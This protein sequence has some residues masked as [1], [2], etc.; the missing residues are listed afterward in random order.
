MDD[1]DRLLVAVLC[2]AT[3]CLDDSYK[4]KN[5]I[6]KAMRMWCD[7]GILLFHLEMRHITSGFQG[8]GVMKKSVVELQIMG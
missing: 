3:R 6:V 4:L 5:F 8:K 7:F 1:G 2:D